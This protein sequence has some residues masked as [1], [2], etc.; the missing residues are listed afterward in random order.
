MRP[1]GRC[2]HPVEPWENSR[3]GSEIPLAPVLSGEFTQGGDGT[4]SRLP[5][6][7]RAG[8]RTSNTHHSSCQS[9]EEKAEV[10][11]G[12]RAGPQLGDS[13]TH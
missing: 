13:P 7:G 4:L 8:P 11:V 3:G 12:W 6:Y 9:D 10:P 2:K 1:S 5:D